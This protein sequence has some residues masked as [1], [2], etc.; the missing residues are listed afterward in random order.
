[1]KTI[2]NNK[3]LAIF[4]LFGSIACGGNDNKENDHGHEHEEEECHGEMKEEEHGEEGIHFTMAQF[5]ALAMKVG[6]IP[7][8]NV[9]AYVETNGQL[10]VPPQNEA[11][12]TAVIGANVS[13][14]EVIEGDKVEKG[15][16]LAYINHPDLIQLQSNYNSNWNEL[17]YLEQ[18]YKRQQKLYDEKVGSGKELQ[19]TKSDYQ[20][21]KSMVNGLAAQLKLLGIPTA[22]VENGTIIEQIAVRSPIKGFVRLVE[23]KTGQY[24]IPQ[25]ELFEIVNLEHIHAD[26]MVFEKDIAKVRE[27][28][29]ITFNVESIEKALEASVY[30]VGKNFEQNPKAIHIHAEIEDKSGLLLPGMYVR[31][32]ILTSGTMG[33]ALPEEAVIRDNGKDY[34]FSA[35]KGKED[36][37]EFTPIEVVAGLTTNGWTEIKLLKPLPSNTKVALN[38]AYYLIA[39]MQKGEA[40]HAH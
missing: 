26:F 22:S 33:R 17:Q 35:K 37:W 14:I 19:R 1:M 23:I 28:Q 4:F 7:I 8:R 3:L 25:T 9:S 10:E 2:Y 13:S 32:R 21:K 5:D 38:S 12:V 36:E 16:V 18:D 29:K 31:G 39:E 27:G 24:V 30:S 15:Q 40:E 20:S 34:I 11:A 6:T